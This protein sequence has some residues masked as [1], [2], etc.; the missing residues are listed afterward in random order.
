MESKSEGS[1][2]EMDGPGGASSITHYDAGDLTIEG[3]MSKK[4]SMF[5]WKRHFIVLDEE[6][7]LSYFTSELALH[8]RG[9]ITL[10]RGVSIGM[11]ARRP[12][13]FVLRDGTRA[14]RFMVEHEAD[15]QPWVSTISK[16]LKRA[17]D[18]FGEAEAKTQE[19]LRRAAPRPASLDQFY[20]DEAKY[21][22]DDVIGHGS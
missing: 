2:V 20:R 22:V 3:Y 1:V 18:L 16:W 13:V 9:K 5:A 8:P 14:F 19:A 15:L 21:E 17:D 10:E 4:A 7:T 6:G 12:N 11:D